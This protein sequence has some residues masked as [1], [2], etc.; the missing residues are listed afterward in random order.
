MN[1]YLIHGSL[2]DSAEVS[3]F[4]EHLEDLK[5]NKPYYIPSDKEFLKYENPD[6]Y[7]ETAEVKTFK[8]HLKK[9]GFKDAEELEEVFLEIMWSIKNGLG[10]PLDFIRVL[11]ETGFEFKSQSMAKKAVESAMAMYNNTRMWTNN[12]HTPNEAGNLK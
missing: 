11:N 12:G 2:Y 10:K 8:E 1:G 7:E 6:Y 5:K 4:V 9:N 3:G